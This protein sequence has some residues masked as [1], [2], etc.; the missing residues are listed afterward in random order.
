MD[1]AFQWLMFFD[2]TQI[3][4]IILALTPS[5]HWASFKTQEPPAATDSAAASPA[6]T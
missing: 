1:K 3:A 2:A 6:T 4:L 5:R